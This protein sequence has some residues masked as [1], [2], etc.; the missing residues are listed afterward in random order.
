LYISISLQSTST[1][2]DQSSLLQDMKIEIEKIP[3]YL[4]KRSSSFRQMIHDIQLL[5]CTTEESNHI[6]N[7][8]ELRQIALLTY[9]TMVIQ[10]YQF[11]WATYLKSG[12]GQLIIATE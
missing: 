9:K 10:T 12:L 4:T 7:I 5:S 11:L 2:I 8:N 6:N 1:N 3:N